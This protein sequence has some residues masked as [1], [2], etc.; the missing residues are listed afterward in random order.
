MHYRWLILLAVIIRLHNPS[1]LTN[2]LTELSVVCLRFSLSSSLQPL[3]IRSN[4]FAKDLINSTYISRIWCYTDRRATQPFR[5]FLPFE[6]IY[7]LDKIQIL[8]LHNTAFT[9]NP[10]PKKSRGKITGDVPD[11]NNSKDR[12]NILFMWF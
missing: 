12:L 4:I 1:H 5:N 2:R 9:P 10:T 3:P 11:D 6:A 8:Y 7:Y